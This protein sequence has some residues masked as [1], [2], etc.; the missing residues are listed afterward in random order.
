M[1]YEMRGIHP[2]A[3]RPSG[4]LRVASSAWASSPANWIE[5]REAGNR[6]REDLELAELETTRE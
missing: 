1:R 2:T 4:S 5:R 3:G 6:A